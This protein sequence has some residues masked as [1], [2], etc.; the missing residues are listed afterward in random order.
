MGD[1]D[2]KVILTRALG[3]KITRTFVTS[4]RFDRTTSKKVATTIDIDLR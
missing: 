4:R 1:A 2:D 3:K